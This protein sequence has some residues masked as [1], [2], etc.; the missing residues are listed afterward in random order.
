MNFHLLWADKSAR[1]KLGIVMVRW[2]RPFDVFHHPIFQHLHARRDSII[3]DIC[4]V[5]QT[6]GKSVSRLSSVNLST[7]AYE[8]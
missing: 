6:S 7:P 8:T 4:H 3:R 1:S 5:I 2:I